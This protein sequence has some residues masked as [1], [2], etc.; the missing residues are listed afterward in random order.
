MNEWTAIGKII[1]SQSTT[2]NVYEGCMRTRGMTDEGVRRWRPQTM[3]ATNHDATTMMATT[4]T[5]TTMI[6][7]TL[8]QFVQ[9][10]HDFGDFLKVRR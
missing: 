1:A 3:M 2:N 6:A 10:R 7:T 5:A 4:M 8:A 9:R